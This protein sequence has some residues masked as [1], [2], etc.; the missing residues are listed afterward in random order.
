MHPLDT[1]SKLESAGLHLQI[2]FLNE[3]SKQ[4][5]LSKLHVYASNLD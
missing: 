4:L 5:S 3:K 1:I 2:M